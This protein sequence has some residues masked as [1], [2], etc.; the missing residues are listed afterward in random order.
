MPCCCASSRSGLFAVLAA[1][2]IVAIGA[3]S[4]EPPAPK[5]EDPKPAAKP[6]QSAAADDRYVLGFT[7]KSIEEK[8]VD[9]AAEFK[10]KVVMVVNVASRCGFTGQYEGLEKLFQERKDK[11]LVILGFPANNFGGQEPGSNEEIAKFCQSK[12]NVTFPMFAKISVKGDDQ[13][14]LYKK[15]AA[16]PAPVGGEPK[17]NFTKFLVDRSGN[18]VARFDSSVRPNDKDMLAKI[19][20]LLT[21]K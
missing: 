10:G 8:D 9:L 16:Q 20:E 12:Y 21:A 18:V 14:P 7:M 2:A 19:D 11:G 1:G 4:H 17:W 13:H 5:K 15:I 3:I 6:S